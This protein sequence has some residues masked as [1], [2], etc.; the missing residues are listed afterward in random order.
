MTPVKPSAGSVASPARVADGE[1]TFAAVLDAVDDA[2]LREPSG[3][4]GWTR[5]HVV[6]H[7]ARNAD[8]LLNLLVWARTGVETPMY[9]DPGARERDIEEAASWPSA[10][11][12]A[13]TEN[14]AE[15]L[16]HAWEA[17]PSGAWDA[18]VR[19]ALGRNIP[20]AETLWMRAREVW[21]HAVDLRG[22]GDF[23]GLPDDVV[24]ALLDDASA[25]LTRRD[26]PDLALLATD[27]DTTW[28]LGHGH[29]EAT[30]K[31]PAHRLLGY[32]LGRAPAPG[33]APALP[34]WL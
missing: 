2:A 15:R 5:A 12:R 1:R 29:A 23:S 8:A 27:R 7:V 11:L 21:V 32:V 13:E 25:T 18:R 26:A 14:A 31:G 17:L 3:L 34:R 30:V 6:G 16:A 9:P 33:P 22:D 19:S 20:A 4:P 24:G 10:R 28:R